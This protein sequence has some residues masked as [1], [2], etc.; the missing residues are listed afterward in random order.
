MSSRACIFYTNCD[1]FNIIICLFST[2]FFVQKSPFETFRTVAA[3]AEGFTALPPCAGSGKAPPC[4]RDFFIKK[5]SKNFNPAAAGVGAFPL[6]FACC[7]ARQK[8][9]GRGGIMQCGWF[10][11]ISI[12]YDV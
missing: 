12:V 9:G 1:I 8:D 10:S 5:S 7:P 2:I 11:W 6:L 3:S 4:T